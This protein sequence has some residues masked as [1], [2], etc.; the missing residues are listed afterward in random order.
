MQSVVTQK[1]ANICCGIVINYI[2][3]YLKHCTTLPNLKINKI[4]RFST[5]RIHFTVYKNLLTYLIQIK[6]FKPFISQ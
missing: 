5:E 1:E 2:I 3:Y 6:K 4:C